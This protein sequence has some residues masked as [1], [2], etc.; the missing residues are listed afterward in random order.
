M[1]SI[2]SHKSPGVDGF[3]SD[4]FKKSW[5]I[6]GHSVCKTVWEFFET[7]VLSPYFQHTLLVLL[8]KVDNL[9]TA[10]EYRPIACGSTMYKCIT[11]LRCLRLVSVLPSI[12][13]QN[14][15]AFV[16][17]RLIL[18]NIL[19]SQELFRGYNREKL[20]HRCVLKVDLHKVYDSVS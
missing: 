9:Q 3:D 4:F 19:L 11:K 6:V 17:D 1:F 14:K 8:P 15:G 7:G 13:S 18:H 20:S 12:I 2:G 5:E 16:K 10:A